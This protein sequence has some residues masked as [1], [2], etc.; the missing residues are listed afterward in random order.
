MNLRALCVLRV[1]RV[2]FQRETRCQQNRALDHQERPTVETNYTQGDP[3]ATG[4]SPRSNPKRRPLDRPRSAIDRDQATA[5]PDWPEPAL[6]LPGLVRSNPHPAGPLRSRHLHLRRSLHGRSPRAS[7]VVLHRRA[8]KEIS[9]L[10]TGAPQDCHDPPAKVSSAPVCRS[11]SGLPSGP[12][13]VERPPF[14]FPFRCITKIHRLT[15][16]RE[17]S[18][19][20]HLREADS[21]PGPFQNDGASAGSRYCLAT[22]RRLHIGPNRRNRHNV[23][24]CRNS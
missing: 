14:A 7:V 24:L 19:D 13:R 16:S 3:C 20:P 23:S 17:F 22:R 8:K 6:P 12:E 1:R 9:R 10:L 5:G 21:P 4:H 18:E 2:E 15:P 11:T